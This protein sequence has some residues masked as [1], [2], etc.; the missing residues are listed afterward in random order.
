MRGIERPFFAGYYHHR[1]LCEVN[2]T[3]ITFQ[4]KP[5]MLHAYRQFYL[6]K[7]LLKRVRAEVAAAWFFWEGSFAYSEKII[8]D[9]DEVQ[10]DLR[11]F[12]AK[13]RAIPNPFESRFT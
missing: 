4:F 10:R 11:A 2:G 13:A 5:A 7:P 8:I 1:W 6:R 12:K 3:E 9:R